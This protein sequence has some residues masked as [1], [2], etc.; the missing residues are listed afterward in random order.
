MRVRSLISAACIL[1][2][3][4]ALSLPT[5]SIAQVPA[6][7]LTIKV[8]GSIKKKEPDWRYV[9]GF[10]TCP[11]LL[12]SQISDDVADWFRK[13][14]DSTSEQVAMQIYMIG[15]QKE[16]VDF[17]SRFSSGRFR[18]HSVIHKYELGDEAF[19]IEYSAEDIKN[20]IQLWMRKDK[21]VIHIDGALPGTVIRFA[22][23]ALKDLPSSPP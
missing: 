22:Q 13:R 7:R 10:C 2:L 9:M 18:A 20:P 3:S 1:P 14:V 11:P 4:G 21:F 6:K 5:S 17:M 19:L 23:Y 16:A 12:P 15:N 8:A